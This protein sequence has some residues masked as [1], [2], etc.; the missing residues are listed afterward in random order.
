MRLSLWAWLLW[1][2]PIYFVLEVGTFLIIG[3][4]LRKAAGEFVGPYLAFALPAVIFFPLVWW[5][6]ILEQQGTSPKRLARGWVL[7][8]SLFFLLVIVATFY[9][10]IE[11]CLMDRKD[12][13]GG[14]VVCTLLCVPSIY[15]MYRRALSVISTRA[16]GKLDVARPK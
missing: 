9:S 7:S 16:A 5:I 11:L 2:L 8:T 14:F 4:I 1:C 6:R 10:G 13:L 12:A 3:S 15:C